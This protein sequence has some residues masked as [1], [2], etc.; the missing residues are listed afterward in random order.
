MT[1]LGVTTTTGAGGGVTTGG[2]VSLLS[3]ADT[4]LRFM[5]NLELKS[6]PESWQAESAAGHRLQII[7]DEGSGKRRWRTSL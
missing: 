7:R 5:T 1:G 3:P 6:K 2:R 4:E